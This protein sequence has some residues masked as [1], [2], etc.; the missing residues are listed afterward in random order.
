[1]REDQCDIP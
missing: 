1:V